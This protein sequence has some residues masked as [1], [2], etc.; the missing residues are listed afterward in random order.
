MINHFTERLYQTDAFEMASYIVSHTGILRELEAEKSQEGLTRKQNVEELLNAIKEF[1][2]ASSTENPEE[3]FY[4]DAFLESVSLQTETEEDKENKDHVS[5]M[6]VHSAKGLE[7]N[8]VFI[9]GA[10]QELFPLHFNGT[11]PENMEEERR[12]FYVA[13]T[14]AKKIANISFAEHRYKWGQLI[15]CQPS[16]FIDE[17]D[18]EYLDLPLAA[19]KLTEP[20][21]YQPKEFKKAPVL[22]SEMLKPAISLKLKEKKLVHL[23]VAEKKARPFDSQME[24]N[25]VEE[26][27]QVVHDRF[28]KGVVVKIEGHNPNAK[29][30]IQFEVSGEKQ[31]LLKFAKLK[32]IHPN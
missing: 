28:G 2:V 26:G 3:T 18:K 10:E 4:L 12:L 32:I 24:S 21:S 1:C 29:A 5:L 13:L 19:A 8:C 7:F 15:S 17:I 27:M 6:T 31:L 16:R 22:Q 20:V 11:S 25:Q 14:R 23:D 9:V 30:V